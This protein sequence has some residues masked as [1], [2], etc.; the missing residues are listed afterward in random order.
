[1]DMLSHNCTSLTATEEYYSVFWYL[2]A[3]LKSG[4]ELITI[5]YREQEIKLIGEIFR[6]VRRVPNTIQT[7]ILL[8][9]YH[10]I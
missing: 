6:R 8:W 10:R 2:F 3:Y 7:L 1:M 5:F 4:Q 9:P